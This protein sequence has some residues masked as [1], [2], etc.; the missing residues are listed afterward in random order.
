[1]NH[2][3]NKA[4]QEI[5]GEGWRQ[6]ISPGL[7]V[8]RQQ[9]KRKKRETFSHEPAWSSERDKRNELTKQLEWDK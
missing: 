8:K 5:F 3:D 1:M 9:G 4:Q 2:D 7:S 6:D